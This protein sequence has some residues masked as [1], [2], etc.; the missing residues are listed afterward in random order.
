MSG[1]A[2][3]PNG[4]TRPSGV[5][6]ISFQEKS[7]CCRPNAIPALPCPPRSDDPVVIFSGNLEY[8]PNRQ[9]MMWFHTAVFPLLKACVWTACDSE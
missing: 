3:V 4:S 2:G 6:R 7:S 1:C 5:E 8:H 9:V